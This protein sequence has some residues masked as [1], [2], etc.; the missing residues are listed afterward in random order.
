[1]TITDEL[2]LHVAGE[3]TT[4]QQR[5]YTARAVYEADMS[6]PLVDAE[7]KPN[8]LDNVIIPAARNIVDKGVAFLFGT[9]PMFNVTE[10]YGEDAQKALERLWRESK[11]PTRLLEIAKHGGIAGQ[12]VFKFE[13]DPED[14][15]QGRHRWVVVDPCYLD[16][17]WDPHDT[18][19]VLLYRFEYP[20]VA[21]DSSGKLIPFVWRQDIEAVRTE[22]DAFGRQVT[23]SWV[24]RNYR[25]EAP[26]EHGTHQR[27]RWLGM[28]VTRISAKWEQ[29]G[30]DYPWPYEWAPVFTGQNLI[31]PNSFWGYSDIEDAVTRLSESLNRSASNI[32]KTIRHHAHPV[33]VVRGGTW[34]E[35]HTI[36]E[37]VEFDL[38]P[39]EIDVANLEMQSDQAAA[40][41]YM[42]E[43][44]AELYDAARIPDVSR[45]KVDNVGQLSGVAMRIMY[46]PLM[47]KT[48]EKRKTYGDA[49]EAALR[50]ALE[51]MGYAPIG[52]ADPDVTLV[53]P[54]PLPKNEKED[55]ETGEIDRR[56][57]LSMR[58]YL[59]RRGFDPD[60]ESENALEEGASDPG[61]RGV[62]DLVGGAEDDAERGEESSTGTDASAANG[63]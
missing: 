55:A 7:G 35:D 38:P 49:L 61:M 54:D 51:Y 53:W 9:E 34:P 23:T 26:S 1:M 17:V 28:G 47:E 8:R 29:V 16:V 37:P 57:G 41:E 30:G 62:L 22:P 45:G 48:G 44:R 32:A 43:L 63:E 46:G 21:P 24:I 56:N 6:A 14:Q 60:V 19:R 42:R 58:T 31:S 27:R 40:L 12:F 20:T 11:M 2:I 13:P 50:C 10:A 4:R 39:S 36:G 18:S 59:E 15:K 52:D 33:T 25:A 5:F 3:P